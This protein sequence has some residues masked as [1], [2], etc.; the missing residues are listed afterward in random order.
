MTKAHAWRGAWLQ[1][2]NFWRGRTNLRTCAKRLRSVRP[3]SLSSVGPEWEGRIAS[4]PAHGSDEQI[5]GAKEQILG[6]DQSD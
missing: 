1:R 6:P 2:T 4:D 5:F 3:Y